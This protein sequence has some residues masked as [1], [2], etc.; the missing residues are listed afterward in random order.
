MVT[1]IYVSAAVKMKGA[2]SGRIE[3]RNS[4]KAVFFQLMITE[5][6]S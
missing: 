2:L 4:Y 5:I 6:S 3:M 1:C